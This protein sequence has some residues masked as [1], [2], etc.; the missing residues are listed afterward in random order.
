[1]CRHSE[2]LLADNHLAYKFDEDWVRNRCEERTYAGDESEAILGKL[3]VSPDHHH[4][5][6]FEH[7]AGSDG[8][9]LLSW[10]LVGVS[11][12]VS[13]PSPCFSCCNPENKSLICQWLLTVLAA[14]L[15]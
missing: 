9:A 13:R 12:H 7:H 6:A 3:H 2:K 15:C 8:R 4:T 5:A 1:M 10:D 14:G 11:V